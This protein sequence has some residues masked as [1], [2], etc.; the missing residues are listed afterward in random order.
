MEQQLSK[1][2]RRVWIMFNYISVALIVLFF[3]IGKTNK[4]IVFFIGGGISL[5]IAGAT[6]YKVFIKTQLW[7]IVHL[8]KSKLDERQMQIVLNALRY[9]YSAFVIITLLLIYG[10][11]IVGK[12]PVNVLVAGCLLYLAHTFPAAFIGWTEEFV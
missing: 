1:Q 2:S 12:E 8:S 6:F 7:K 9:S 5:L 11:A 3:Y 4:P 10:F